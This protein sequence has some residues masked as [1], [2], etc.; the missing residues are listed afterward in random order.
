MF[1]R[2]STA[3]YNSNPTFEFGPNAIR[4]VVCKQPYRPPHDNRCLRRQACKSKMARQSRAA[5]KEADAIIAS[6]SRAN[7]AAVETTLDGIAEK[8]RNNVPL[9]YHIHALLNNAEWTAVLEASIQ[10]VAMEKCGE[11]PG[12]KN[13]YG[14]CARVRGS[15][16]IWTGG[17]RLF[18]CS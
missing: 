8:L 15:S 18:L 9:M 16:F 4:V 5:E 7:D 17:R 2:D 1:K 12:N 11:K 10:G 13:K 14:I 6:L 3:N